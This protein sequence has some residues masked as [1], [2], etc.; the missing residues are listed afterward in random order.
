MGEKNELTSHNSKDTSFAP[1]KPHLFKTD[2][3]ETHA[4]SF[5]SQSEKVLSKGF[6]KLYD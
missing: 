6:E 5:K 4:G 2:V 1:L 3:R